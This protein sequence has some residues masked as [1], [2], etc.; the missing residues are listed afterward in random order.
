MVAYGFCMVCHS[1]NMKLLLRDVIFSVLLD[2]RIA[3]WSRWLL[4]DN[5]VLGKWSSHFPK[6]HIWNHNLWVS[7]LEFN[8]LIYVTVILCTSLLMSH[9]ERHETFFIFLCVCSY[10]RETT[11]ASVT[12]EINL[13]WSCLRLQDSFHS[14]SSCFSILWYPLFVILVHTFLRLLSFWDVCIYLGKSLH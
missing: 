11:F 2:G 1:N 12:V 5:C 14:H 13:G 4:L 3:L 7:S 6:M 8:I 9:H 10:G